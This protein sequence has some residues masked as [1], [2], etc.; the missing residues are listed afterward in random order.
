MAELDMLEV[1]TIA[2][3]FSTEWFKGTIVN[4]KVIERI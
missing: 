3:Q 4:S 2:K 1:V